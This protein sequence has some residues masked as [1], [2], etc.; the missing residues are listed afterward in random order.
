MG[1]SIAS[2]PVKKTETQENDVSFFMKNHKLK[3]TNE[4]VFKEEVKKLKKKSSEKKLIT[5]ENCIEEKIKF[6]ESKEKKV[7]VILS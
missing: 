2:N 3:E 1:I 6:W 4:C 7:L 5:K